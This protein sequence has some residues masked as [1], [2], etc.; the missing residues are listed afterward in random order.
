MILTSTHT[1]NH[2]LQP[3]R[4]FVTEEA[5]RAGACGSIFFTPPQLTTSLAVRSAALQN[6]S[7]LPQPYDST[8]PS[9]PTSR[10]DPNGSLQQDPNLA[11]QDPDSLAPTPEQ[12]PKIQASLA[13]T[14]DAEV[15]AYCTGAGDVFAVI[16]AR[17][18]A[19]PMTFFTLWD[20]MAGPGM[21]GKLDPQ[22]VRAINF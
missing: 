18:R 13:N 2:L 7:L 16:I 14:Y 17:F 8:L 12:N 10:N 19:D 21:R 4:H 6:H 20:V 9:S 3:C 1:Y 5:Q 15:A 11:P 22:Q